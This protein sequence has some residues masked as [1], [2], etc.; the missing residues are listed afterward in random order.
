M[1]QNEANLV[2]KPMR[3]AY[4]GRW[5]YQRFEDRWAKGVPDLAYAATQD[6]TGWIELKYSPKVAKEGLVQQL[7]H[8]TD[9]QRDWLTSWPMTHMLWRIGNEWLLFRQGWSLIGHV[10]FRNLIDVADRHWSGG[11]DWDQLYIELHIK[12]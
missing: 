9:E 10:A 12:R 7:P 6:R 4:K 11:M 8:Y 2:W 3:T 1:A 5:T